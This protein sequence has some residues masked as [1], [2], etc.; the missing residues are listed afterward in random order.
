[1]SLIGIFLAHTPLYFN[2]FYYIKPKPLQNP[3]K[4]LPTN[5]ELL[6]DVKTSQLIYS[7][8]ELY[9]FYIMETLLLQNTKK[10]WFE[11]FLRITSN[12]CLQY[13]VNLSELCN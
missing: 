7:T 9:V 8:N 3:W 6:Y 5:E 1:M 4:H 13:K 2:V 11:Y 10:R 12:F